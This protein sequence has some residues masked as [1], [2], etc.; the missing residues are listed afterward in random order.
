MIIIQSITKKYKIRDSNLELLRII[1]M[2]FI[3]LHHYAYHGS[4][5]W[6]QQYNKLF[7]N[8]DKIY[9]FLSCLGKAAVVAFVMIGAWFLSEKEFKIWR[10]IQLCMTTFIYSWLIFLF[11]RWKFSSLIN[12][13]SM[14]NIWW[15]IPIPS[16]YWFVIAYVYMLLFMP[17][18]NLIIKKTT[19]R[20]II[21][22]I[23]VF[24]ILWTTIQF[25]PNK[26]LDNDNYNFFD[27][28]NYFLLIYVIAGYLRKYKPKWSKGFF[29]SLCILILSILVILV[30]IYNIP[31]KD[32]SFFA[33][34]MASLSNPFSLILGIALFVFFNNVHLGHSI[35]IN[36]VSKSMFGVY[37]IHDNSF[38]RTILWHKVINTLPYA[39]SPLKYLKYGLIVSVIIF[40]TCIIID[41]IKRLTIDP[42]F[43][44]LG[45]KCTNKIRTWSNKAS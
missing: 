29:K 24:T 34:L 25:I 1:S 3:V 9:L 31:N 35:V 16:N 41:I 22:I 33:V 21:I 8:S 27:F 4:F 2:F 10:V 30:T 45:L 36:Y 43:N 18:M 32:Y 5:I 11:L 17:F 15:P 12:V 14:N 40:I 39:Q 28:N 20:Q 26:K 23:I 6:T 13:E 19:K 38:V 44:Y 7:W 42:I 37:L